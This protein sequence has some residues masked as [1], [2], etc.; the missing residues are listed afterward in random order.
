METNISEMTQDGVV[1]AVAMEM[2]AL[3]LLV[4]G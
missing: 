4:S 1:G 2:A 3:A